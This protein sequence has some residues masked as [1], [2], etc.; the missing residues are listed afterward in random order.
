[1]IVADFRFFLSACKITKNFQENQKTAMIF[2]NN[3]MTF[4]KNKE[5]AFT[6]FSYL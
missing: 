6:P 5:W 1:M 3:P 2:A 4:S